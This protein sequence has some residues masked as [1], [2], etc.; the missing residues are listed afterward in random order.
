M[1]TPRL[2]A[3]GPV[4]LRQVWGE[5]WLAMTFLTT[6]PAPRFFATAGTCDA[7]SLA[8]R[9]N[10][11]AAGYLDVEAPEESLLL[12]KPLSESAGGTEH[13]GHAKFATTQDATYAAFLT[14]VE[15][16]GSCRD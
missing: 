8:T 11:H 10:V 13:G 9:R 1:A 14:Y 6:L 15:R 2:N 5:F 4:P 16:V 12:L 7:A 3:P